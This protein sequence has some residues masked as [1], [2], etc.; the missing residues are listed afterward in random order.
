MDPPTT[1]TPSSLAA[2]DSI[3][4]DGIDSLLM[5]AAHVGTASAYLGKE[6]VSYGLL[7]HSGSTS[8][9]APVFAADLRAASAVIRLAVLS[10]PTRIWQAATLRREAADA[11][12]SWGLVKA[13]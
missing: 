9:C 6:A 7:K 10:G 2:A 12:S 3:A 1:N 5:S 13:P 4:D 11:I 8:S